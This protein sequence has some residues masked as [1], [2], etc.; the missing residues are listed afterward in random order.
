[1]EIEFTAK[2]WEWQGQGAWCFVSLPSEYYETIKEFSA[3][4]KRG[5]GSLRI[6]ATIGKISWRTSIFPDSKTRTYLLP[7]KKY[8]RGK[9]HIKVGDSVKVNLI[10][11]EV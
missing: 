4:P 1:M 9:A 8:V 7:V 10:L 11:V 2:L 6:E 5:F 3:G